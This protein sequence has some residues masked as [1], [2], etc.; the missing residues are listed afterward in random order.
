MSDPDALREPTPPPQPPR[1][2][3][4]P[5]A[6]D[7]ATSTS[8]NQLEAD[9]LYARQLAEHYS[10][11]ASYVPDLGRRNVTRDPPLPARRKETGLRPNELQD[12][13]H[14]FLDGRSK[15]TSASDAESASSGG[16]N[17]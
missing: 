1:P 9:E 12:G 5:L 17:L 10:G 2:A 7:Q 15:E 11:T 4:S 6:S 14:S 8:Q 13:D 3:R 16:V